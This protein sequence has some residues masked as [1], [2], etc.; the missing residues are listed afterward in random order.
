MKNLFFVFLP[1]GKEDKH[2]SFGGVLY[3]R[4]LE[5]AKEI[6]REVGGEVRVAQIYFN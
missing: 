3:C 2:I 5:D 6:A 4:G 1:Q